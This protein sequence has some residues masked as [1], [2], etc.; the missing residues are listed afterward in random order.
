FLDNLFPYTLLQT[1]LGKYLFETD[2][3]I[4]KNLYLFN[5]RR[6]HAFALGF[7]VIVSRLRNN[8]I[9]ADILS[10]SSCFNRLNHGDLL[11]WQKLSKCEWHDYAGHLHNRCH[12][13]FNIV[14]KNNLAT[15]F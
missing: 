8:D 3:L 15:R 11:H 13:M 6:F 5:I 1:E 7:S 10:S 9:L 12:S 14:N 2:T 4:L